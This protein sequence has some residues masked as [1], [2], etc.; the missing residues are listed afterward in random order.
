VHKCYTAIYPAHK[1]HDALCAAALVDGDV[2]NTA[3]AVA[4]A[5][6][7]GGG[8]AAQGLEL[9]D[10]YDMLM[11]DSPLD[12]PS[13]APRLR[14]F[15]AATDVRGVLAVANLPVSLDAQ[16]HDWCRLRLVKGPFAE[17][18]DRALQRYEREGCELSALHPPANARRYA[19]QVPSLATDELVE[20]LL[21]AHLALRREEL[22]PL[23]ELYALADASGDGLL[24]IETF[25]EKL[26]HAACA[27]SGSRRAVAEDECEELYLEA[28]RESRMREPAAAEDAIS[29]DA[30][31]AVAMRHALASGQADG[32]GLVLAGP[33]VESAVQLSYEPAFSD[34]ERAAAAAASNASPSKRGTGAGPRK[35]SA[36]M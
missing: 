4:F 32:F 8:R 22:R 15:Y 5:A 12:E 13:G 11:D 23:R 9:D 16:V 26:V 33:L 7:R 20:M 3:Q 29:A 14:G 35:A 17:P 21:R 34:E 27:L 19:A 36:L 6:E 1:L 28:V 31:E 10:D 25:S 2:A 30:W 24:T 18:L